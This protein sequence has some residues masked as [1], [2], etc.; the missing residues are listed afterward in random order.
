M[1]EPKFPIPP[2]PFREFKT[3]EEFRVHLEK[4]REAERQA[5][6]MIAPWQAALT[7]GDKVCY[8]FTYADGTPITIYYEI[9]RS[10]YKEDTHR[11]NEMW[12]RRVYGWGYSVFC[13]DGEPGS[14]HRTAFE[15][16][17]TEDEWMAAM[18][19]I[20]GVHAV[21]RAMLK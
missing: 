15:R 17:L 18:A 8:Q 6:A 4:R 5:D 1:A 14:T 3:G 2:L 12:P 16:K 13:P 9:K 11:E 20:Q 7:W 21:R 10:P 19:E